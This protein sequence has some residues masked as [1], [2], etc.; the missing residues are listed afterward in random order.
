MMRPSGPLPCLVA[1]GHL[2]DA[3][4]RAYRALGFNAAV[5]GDE[6]F[7]DLVLA[8]IIEPTSRLDSLQVPPRCV[9]LRAIA[10]GRPP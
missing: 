6:V 5:R 3:L 8:R 4:R 9:A 7:R 10:R 2:W 1:A